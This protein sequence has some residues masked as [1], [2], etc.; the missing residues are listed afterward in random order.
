[1]KAACGDATRPFYEVIVTVAR[2]ADDARHPSIIPSGGHP[3]DGGKSVR[4]VPIIHHHVAAIDLVEIGPTG[5]IVTVKALERAA[6]MLNRDS[7]C[8]A[9]SN[10]G[11]EITDLKFG[12]PAHRA[13]NIRH[14]KHRMLCPVTDLDNQTIT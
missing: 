12:S 8:S 1:M 13:W 3:T 2:H 6:E 14:T 4:V 9:R 7:V 5:I 10:R 11:E